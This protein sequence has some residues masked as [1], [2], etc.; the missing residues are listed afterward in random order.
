MLERFHCTSLPVR[1]LNCANDRAQR[2]RSI[3]LMNLAGSD[4]VRVVCGRTLT[5]FELDGSSFICMADSYLAHSN[6]EV[7]LIGAQC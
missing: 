2:Y 3:L 5:G 4:P 6:A 7:N 1:R